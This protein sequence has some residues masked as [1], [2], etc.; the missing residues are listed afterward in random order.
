MNPKGFGLARKIAQKSQ[1]KFKLG[2]VIMDKSRVITV[3][4]ND[5]HRTHT[6]CNTYGNYL[7]AEIRAL[8]GT[9]YN[10]TKGCTAY[11]YRET[12]KGEL[13]M[14]KPCP[15]CKQAL[16]LAGIRKIFYTSTLGYE[17]EQL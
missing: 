16:I 9:D 1:S 12:R 7:H 11:I 6:K 3:G 14:A 13:A 5:M 17:K 2:C 4:W 10:K 8:L 15:I